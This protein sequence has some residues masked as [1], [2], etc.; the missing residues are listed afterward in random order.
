M[1]TWFG[2]DPGC[3]TLG[4]IMPVLAVLGLILIFEWVIRLAC[5]LFS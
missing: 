1:A 5:W 3:F 4:C 2:V